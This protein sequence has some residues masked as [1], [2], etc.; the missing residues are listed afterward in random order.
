MGRGMETTRYLRGELIVDNY[1]A[2]AIMAAGFTL[3]VAACQLGG[4]L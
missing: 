3:L 4:S 2:Y 1:I